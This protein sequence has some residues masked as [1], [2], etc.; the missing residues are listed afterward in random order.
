[1]N[2]TKLITRFLGLGSVLAAALTLTATRLPAG[3]PIPLNAQ[4]RTSAAVVHASAVSMSCASCTTV[5]IT[6]RRQMPGTKEGTALYTVGSRHGCAMCGGEIV[7]LNGK[8]TSSMQ[9][10]C[11]VCAQV[12]VSCCGVPSSTKNG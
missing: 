12:A 10:N 9:R 8:T 1:M 11:A 3:A 2:T 6:E 5:A 7:T 4:H